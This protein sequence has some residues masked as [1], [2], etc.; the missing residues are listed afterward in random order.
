ML[1][2]AKRPV[3]SALMLLAVIAL[4]AVGTVLAQDDDGEG[5]AEPVTTEEAEATE[6]AGT[7]DVPD[8]DSDD[9]AER[10]EYLVRVEISCV[11]CHGAEGYRDDPLGVALS[12]GRAFQLGPI[13][14]V[15]APNLTT[16][17]DWSDQE[18]E[19]AIRYG[20]G[21]D[22]ETLLPPMSYKL[23]EAMADADMEAIIAYLRT[24]E[25]VQNEIPETE[26]GQDFTRER[27]RTVPAFDEDATYDYPEG[28]EDDPVVRGEYMVQ[29]TSHCL[30]CHGQPLEGENVGMVP[31]AN[32]NAPP[33]GEMIPMYPAL[34]ED[35]L[36]RY[37]DDD[38][39]DLFHDLSL[40]EMP[41]YSY[42]YMVDEDIEA[43]IA[44]LREQPSMS[45]LALQSEE[46]TEEA[47]E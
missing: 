26:L 21:P 43:L 41:T 11:G 42:Q 20:V 35:N 23:H 36:S 4:L 29:H 34:L 38:L 7:V 19:N 32:P 6:E 30:A 3:L 16:L 5:P 28:M 12:G 27:I 25:P 1:N 9:I 14:T 45:D 40:M 44:W 13:G 15:Y 18:I 31:P 17:G 39:Y 37:T 46:A 2:R 33:T 22:G 10:G 47:G 8:K 24:L